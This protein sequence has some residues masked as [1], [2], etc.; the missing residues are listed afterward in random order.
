VALLVGCALE[1]SPV[2]SDVELDDGGATDVPGLD[3]PATDA[4]LED[5]PEPSDTPPDASICAP[6]SE[7]CD[8]RDEDCNGTIDDGGACQTSGACVAFTVAGIA[9]Q[10]CPAITGLDGWRGAC[11]RMGP[12]G[13]D[14]AVFPS[15]VDQDQ[16]RDRLATLGL[17]EPHWVGLNDFEANGTYVW[18]DRISR[19]TP[20]LSADPAKRCVI[21]RVDGTY[22]ELQCDQLQRVLCSVSLSSRACDLGDEGDACDRIDQDCDGT[23]DEG[24]DCGGSCDAHTFWDHVYYVCSSDRTMDVADERCDADMAG[25]SLA[26]IEHATELAFVSSL[27]GASAWVALK[28]SGGAAGAAAGW[29]WPASTNE[30]GVPPASPPWAPGEPNDGDGGGVVEDGE[31]D[32]AVVDPPRTAFDDRRCSGT[33]DSVC[34]GT[35][36]R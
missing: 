36:S 23:V 33:E 32:C 7:S 12:A 5:V 13:Y 8:R 21:F 4:P 11:R 16:V 24:N 34:E 3:V 9:Y 28:Q 35:W 27:G 14:L 29:S 26:S 18:L 17:T 15:P 20:P 19:A 31:E 1:R 22:E 6:T 30:F 10:S 2:T 25:A